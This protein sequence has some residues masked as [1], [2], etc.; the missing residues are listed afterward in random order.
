[1][2]KDYAISRMK[3]MI[4]MEELLYERID[5]WIVIGIKKYLYRIIILDRMISATNL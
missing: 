2:I 3:E 1:M 5:D 4:L